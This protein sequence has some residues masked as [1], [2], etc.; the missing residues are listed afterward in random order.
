MYIYWCVWVSSRTSGSHCLYGNKT[1]GRATPRRHFTSYRVLCVFR[2]RSSHLCANIAICVYRSRIGCVVLRVLSSV[3]TFKFSSVFLP[4][5]FQVAFSMTTASAV[6]K[7]DTGSVAPSISI[8]QVTHTPQANRVSAADKDAATQGYIVAVM[9][10]R[11]VT[12]QV[13]IAAFDPNTLDC[14]L[15][16]VLIHVVVS[17]SLDRFPSFPIVRPT[18]LPCDLYIVSIRIKS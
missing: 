14:F 11:G 15:G 17:V 5:F 4:F 13:G 10:S 9:E 2:A 8:E 18:V 1:M 3:C 16:Q 7:R 6:K 12:A